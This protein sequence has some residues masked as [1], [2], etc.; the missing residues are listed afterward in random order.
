MPSRLQRIVEFN[1]FGADTARVDQPG[2]DLA[3][4]R[5]EEVRLI[6][7]VLAVKYRDVRGQAMVPG[8]GFNPQFPVIRRFWFECAGIT[9]LHVKEHVVGRAFVA[10]RIGQIGGDGVGQVVLQAKP[11]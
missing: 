8:R 4:D 11:T 3:C 7:V 2:N 6:I 10:S 1:A 9:R 5:V